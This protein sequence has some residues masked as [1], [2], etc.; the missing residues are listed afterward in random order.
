MNYWDGCEKMTDTEVDEC[1]AR[2]ALALDRGWF[3][4]TSLASDGITECRSL[5]PPGRL[6]L[7]LSK[8]EVSLPIFQVAELPELPNVESQTNGAGPVVDFEI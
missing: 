1:L 2:A 3:W 7:R 8:A 4:T 6:F 5:V